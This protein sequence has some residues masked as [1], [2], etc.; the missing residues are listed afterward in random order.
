MEA[1]IG[2]ETDFSLLRQKHPNLLRVLQEIRPSSPVCRVRDPEQP[3]QGYLKPR[4]ADSELARIH[5]LQTQE[6][7]EAILQCKALHNEKLAP[8][9]QQE[10]TLSIGQSRLLQKRRFKTC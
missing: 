2:I 10:V 3:A 6:K 9:L 7:A 1:V 4:S 8:S 5:F